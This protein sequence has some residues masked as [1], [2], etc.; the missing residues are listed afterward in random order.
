MC[1]CDTLRFPIDGRSFW[2]NPS[3]PQQVQSNPHQMNLIYLSSS[4]FSHAA[5]Q[6]QAFNQLFLSLEKP[7]CLAYALPYLLQRGVIR[8]QKHLNNTCLQSSRPSHLV[9]TS[10]NL[11]RCGT[12]SSTNIQGPHVVRR[13]FLILTAAPQIP[14]WTIGSRAE[15]L[16]NSPLQH[17]R[18]HE[19]L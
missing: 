19:Q 12:I 15:A 14:D 18:R 4:H 5:Q 6:C 1:S 10:G 8:R 16:Y 2:S 13:S 7:T 17:I 11:L 9:F 3:L